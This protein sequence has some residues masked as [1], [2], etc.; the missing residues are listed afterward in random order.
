MQ[1]EDKNGC[2]LEGISTGDIADRLTAA[3]IPTPMDHKRSQGMRYS[4]W[5]AGMVLRILKNPVL[6]R[7]VGAGA[8][9]HPQL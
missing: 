9:D 8:C 2:I 5:D 6:Y 3:G 1:R 7:R 4:T